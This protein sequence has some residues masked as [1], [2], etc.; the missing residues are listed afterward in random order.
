MYDSFQNWPWVTQGGRQSCLS[1]PSVYN[2][3]SFSLFIIHLTRIIGGSASCQ[4]LCQVK[5]RHRWTRQDFYPRGVHIEWQS[6]TCKQLGTFIYTYIFIKFRFVMKSPE[7]CGERHRINRKCGYVVMIPISCGHE[8]QPRA[9]KELDWAS[10]VLDSVKG[11]IL[12]T[13]KMI[14]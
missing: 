13:L 10:E 3:A 11:R 7:L 12:I 5:R 2:S 1:A 9:K 8:F 14:H 4:V 6:Q